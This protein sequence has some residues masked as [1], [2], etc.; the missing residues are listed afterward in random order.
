[1]VVTG[2]IAILLQHVSVDQDNAMINTPHQVS[3]VEKQMITL[4]AQ[5]CKSQELYLGEGRC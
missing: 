2:P 3:Q 5:S 1:M 4:L